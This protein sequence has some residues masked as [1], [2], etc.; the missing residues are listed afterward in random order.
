MLDG[1]GEAADDIPVV[2]CTPESSQVNIYRVPPQSWAD[3]IFIYAYPPMPTAI[4]PAPPAISPPNEGMILGARYAA[5]Q[6]LAKEAERWSDT[7]T[8]KLDDSSKVR[9]TLTFISPEL[10][11]AVFLS[12][13][14]KDRFLTTGFQDQLQSTLNGV[15]DRDELLFLL[16]VTSS[17]SD[18]MNPI[19]HKIQIP[20][21]SMNLNNAENL[22]VPSTHDDHNLEQII[23][24]ASEPVFG[25]LAYPLAMLSGTQCKWIM[26]PKYNTNIVVTVPTIKVDGNGTGEHSWTIPYASLIDPI[27]PPDPPNFIIPPG[28]DTNLMVPLDLPPT[29]FNQA[30][31]WQNFARFIWSQLTLGKY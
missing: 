10:I 7:E 25:Y 28:F 22:I 13:V 9:I 23:D 3:A 18:N 14:L 19:P 21:D 26:D 27:L 15:A 17:N 24:T 6:Q 1:C 11:Q 31:Y 5:F 4:P 29:E 20:I 16:T 30:D 2:F 12:D 8:I